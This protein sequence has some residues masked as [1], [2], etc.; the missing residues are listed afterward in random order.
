MEIEKFFSGYCR[1]I[2]G[3][4]T[5]AAELENGHLTEAD[6]DYGNCPYRADCP[7]AKELDKLN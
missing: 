5:V 3:S 6:C 2:D 4:R 1:R 7:I